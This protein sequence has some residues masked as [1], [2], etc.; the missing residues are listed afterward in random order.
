MYTQVSP[1]GGSQGRPTTQTYRDRAS[2]GGPRRASTQVSVFVLSRKTFLLAL[3][4][5]Q[6]VL[7]SSWRRFR[8]VSGLFLVPKSTAGQASDFLT[9]SRT[10]C[11]LSPTPDG[12]SC[13]LRTRFSDFCCD[14]SACRALGAFGCCP[15]IF[16]WCL[17]RRFGAPLGGNRRSLGVLQTRLGAWVFPGPSIFRSFC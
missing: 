12:R 11:L 14:A 3:D 1:G 9:M 16:S 13:L 5:C 8:V 10:V 7:S 17:L 6:R 15:S 2:V 4:L